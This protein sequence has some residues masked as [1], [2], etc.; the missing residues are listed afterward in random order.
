M[1]IIEKI[2]SDKKRKPLIY[3]LL[4]VGILM[5]VCANSPMRDFSYRTDTKK[6]QVDFTIKEEMQN[7]L[8]QIDGVGEVSVMLS[9]ESDAEKK[10]RIC[11]VLVVADGGKNAC[12]KE[13]ILRAVKAALGVETHKIEVLERKD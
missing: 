1:K 7:I 8:S 11:S 12:V 2:L 9:Y 3:I 6:M 10:G 13:K 5:L 4:A